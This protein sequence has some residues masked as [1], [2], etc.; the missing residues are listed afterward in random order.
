[1]HS[2]T[3]AALVRA[4][5]DDIEAMRRAACRELRGRG[6]KRGWQAYGL[7][8]R[9][10]QLAALFL[11]PQDPFDAVGVVAGPA[12]FER[13][14][15]RWPS[16]VL[17]A[18][19]DGRRE[20]RIDFRNQRLDVFVLSPSLWPADDQC[21]EGRE[22]LGEVEFRV[23][24]VDAFFRRLEQVEGDLKSRL[25]PLPA[26]PAAPGRFLLAHVS[27]ARGARTVLV[28]LLPFAA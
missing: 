27:Q 12:T 4:L 14:R 24:D 25:T 11:T 18:D 2:Y 15:A 16:A 20:L 13:L 9:D 1:L 8:T 3:D 5:A 28:Q 10:P 7:L 17:R 6:E 23:A 21:P 19:E 26:A 22:G